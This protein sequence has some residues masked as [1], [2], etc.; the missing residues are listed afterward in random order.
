MGSGMWVC[1]VDGSL[2]CTESGH[3]RPTSVL[4][5]QTVNIVYAESKK[6]FLKHLATVNLLNE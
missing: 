6:T 1:Y 2:S 4:G 3:L 5:A